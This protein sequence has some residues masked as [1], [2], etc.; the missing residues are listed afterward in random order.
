MEVSF[1]IFNVGRVKKFTY[2]CNAYDDGLGLKTFIGRVVAL[3]ATNFTVNVIGNF[4]CNSTSAASDGKYY[5]FV[6][7]YSGEGDVTID[8]SECNLILP[9]ANFMYVKNVRVKNCYVRYS[10][11]AVTA[12]TGDNAKFIDCTVRGVFNGSNVS[13][14]FKGANIHCVGCYV[15]VEQTGGNIYGFD[16]TESII[17]RCIV[18]IKSNFSA[19]G[20]RALES[21]QVSN[22][23]FSALSTNTGTNYSGTA[24]IGGGNFTNCIFIGRGGVAG[25]GFV[26]S[27]GYV[28]NSV[29]CTYRG[30][31]ASSTGTGI[32]FRSNNSDTNGVFLL[33]VNCNQVIL[34]GYTQ[35]QS[36]RVYG[37]GAVAGHFYSAAT[38]ASTI[39]QISVINRNRIN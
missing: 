22:S 33:G 24:G 7:E 19:Y 25:N 16:V 11:N 32:G 8:F 27:D 9:G 12:F 14:C 21:S 4:Y 28:V 17:D 5:H 10:R 39:N 31:T 26:Q 13:T 15:G 29:N 18:H 2:H 34:S 30:Y 3:G 35:T 6:Y 20:V 37:H 36:A 23:R 38:F 1:M